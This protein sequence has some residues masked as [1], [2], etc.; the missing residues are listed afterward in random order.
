MDDISVNVIRNL[1]KENLAQKLFDST[2]LLGQ[3]QKVLQVSSAEVDR[4]KNKVI[5][6]QGEKLASVT[7]FSTVATPNRWPMSYSVS[8]H[9][10]S[11]TPVIPV[12]RSTPDKPIS[13]EGRDTRDKNVMLF[14]VSEREDE[15]TE[16]LV[17]N[18]LN[19]TGEKQHFVEC[20]RVGKK[21]LGV[22]P[23]PI[24]V[25]MRNYVAAS[26]AIDSGQKLRGTSGS[27]RVYISPDRSPIQRAERR[28][29][30]SIMRERRK[31]D[32]SQYHFIHRG[33][34]FSARNGSF[35]RLLQNH[36]TM[37][38]VALLVLSSELQPNKCQEKLISYQTM[39][40]MYRTQIQ[41]HRSSMDFYIN[42]KELL[43]THLMNVDI[44]ILFID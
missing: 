20:V 2:Q 19:V 31:T 1:D 24:K 40:L 39:M 41:W 15:E 30:V 36:R 38:Q 10:S 17:E 25:Q 11:D 4:L 29:L 16:I 22:K 42:P 23:R 33:D 14:G 7:E 9:L 18:I 8:L 3:C 34:L 13:G 27:Q 28:R 43:G 12:P 21:G 26:Q 44:R 32:P 6:L 37:I 5:S 35:L